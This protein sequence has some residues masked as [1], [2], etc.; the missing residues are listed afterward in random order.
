MKYLRRFFL[1]FL[2]VFLAPAGV[3]TLVWWLSPHPQSW[4]DAD[5]S[6]AGI[7]PA[8]AATPQ[9]EI[10]VFVA[11]TGGFKGAVA[12]HSWIVL[13]PAGASRWTRYDVVGWGSPVRVN[14]Y[15]P[16]GRW[17]G[18]PP[19]L[20][21]RVEGQ[22]AQAAIPRMMAA[23]QTYRWRHPGDY[24]IWPGPNSNTF[25]ATVLAAVPELGIRQPATAIGKMWPADGAIARLAPDHKGFRFSLW[26]VVGLNMGWD[27]GIELTLAGLT[28]AID[29]RRPALELPGF[30]RLGV[31]PT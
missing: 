22:A 23:I 17:Y 31:S 3:H 5:W 1:F 19:E 14:A 25:V 8:A 9:A 6:S 29:L 20:I 15:T 11:R 4:R 24:V 28:A 10:R 26:G 7:L 27:D 2:I 16:D 18:N 12:Q 30:D 13:K 21:G